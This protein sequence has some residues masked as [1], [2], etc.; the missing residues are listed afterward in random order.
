MVN[1]QNHN[2]IDYY[3]CSCCSLHHLWVAYRFEHGTVQY[4]TVVFIVA[5]ILLLLLL[6]LMLLLVTCFCPDHSTL[7]NHRLKLKLLFIVW[8][9][10]LG[11]TRFTFLI[12]FSE[13]DSDTHMHRFS[14]ESLSPFV[15]LFEFVSSNALNSTEKLWKRK[16]S[17]SLSLSLSL[18]ASFTHVP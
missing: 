1:V 8:Q 4:D 6:L 12:N 13:V 14:F 9:T 15:S 17:L 10:M 7:K 5:L 3:C 11:Y 18:S 2:W 16:A